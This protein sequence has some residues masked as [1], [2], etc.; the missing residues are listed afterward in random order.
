MAVVILLFLLVGLLVYR[1][2]QAAV[3]KQLLPLREELT[4]A[5]AHLANGAD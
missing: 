2:N 5:L 3:R 4:G 1:L